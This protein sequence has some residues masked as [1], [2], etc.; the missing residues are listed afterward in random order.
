MSADFN[1]GS[2]EGTLDIDLGPF[3]AGL[4]KAQMQAAD[5]EK[6]HLTAVADLDTKELTAKKAVADRELDKLDHKKATAK[7]DLDIAP[8]LAKLAI[9]DAALK[10]SFDV[11]GLGGAV[12]SK[13]LLASKFA[14]IAGGLLTITAAAGPAGAAMVGF[15]AASA[16]A[17]AG[18]EG[19]LGLFVAAASSDFSKIQKAAQKGLDLTGPAGLAETALKHVEGAWKS[20]LRQT[21]GPVFKVMTDAFNGAATILPKLAPLL[22]ATARGVDGIVNKVSA[23][24]HTTFFSHFLTQLAGFMHGFLHGA[25]PVIVGLLHSLM[26]GFEALQPLMSMLGKGIEQLVKGAEH[27]TT[28]GGLRKFVQYVVAETPQVLRLLGAVVR[29]LEN[30]GKGIA[31]LAGPALH[32]ITTL[33]QALGNLNLAPFA[34]GF[35]AVLKAAS[36]LLHV[37]SVLLNTV[38]K[39]VGNLLGSLAHHVITPLA[40]SLGSELHPAFHALSQILNALVKP[41]SQ[42]LGSIANLV[43]PTGV[44]FLT[45]LLQLLVKPIQTLAPALGRLVTAFEGVID[46]GIKAITPLLP[47]LQPLLN[48]VAHAAASLAD[49]MAKIISHKDVAL[50]LLAMV[51]AFKG[52]QLISGVVGSMKAFVGTLR[53]LLELQKV[54][55]FMGALAAVAPKLAAGMDL[56]G[57]AIDFM[58]GPWGLL[59]LAASALVVGFIE[60][61]K[62]SETFRNI[63]NGAL[64]AVAD[65]AKAVFN[66]LKNAVVDVVTWIKNHWQLLVGIFLGPMGV[67]VA[68]V[69]T[70]WSQ[71]RDFITNAMHVV[72]SVLTG[73]WHGIEDGWQ[74]LGNMLHSVY[75]H[76]IQP[77]WDTF[78]RAVGDVKSAFGHAVDGIKSAWDRL[79]GVAEAPVRFVVGT[80]ID[81]GIIG[82]MN[83]VA[84]FFHLPSIPTVP[85]PF[86]TGGSVPGHAP[87]DT[88]DNVTARLTPGEFVVKRKSAM[89][90]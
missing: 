38:L 56:I 9:I 77:V 88:A 43:N 85:V 35:G 39:P 62:H 71:I 87:T 3:T 5:F 63:V 1:A 23:F 11:G 12:T 22:D 84:G 79:Q 26:A 36:P 80:V 73:I 27:F 29:G 69:I 81:K 40:H 16:T 28:G 20:L 33:V 76:T 46:Q 52:L 13:S 4:R 86:S 34:R 48:N 72:L 74:A 51:G 60:A 24:A 61:Y 55:G 47:K 14:A 17:M 82:S 64:H 8:F 25:G 15:G 18:V 83:K 41:L 44:H 7:A 42:F 2:I 90:I 30:L 67:V 53:T 66:W 59:I 31:P 78:K 70:H 10:R 50:A 65:V 32:F 54:E 75:Q 68:M 49:G 37:L 58:L 6:K 45:Q 57:G 19:S 89:K 21:A